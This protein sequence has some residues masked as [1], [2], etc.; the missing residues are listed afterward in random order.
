MTNEPLISQRHESVLSEEEIFDVS[1]TTFHLFDR[2][3]AGAPA[4]TRPLKKGGPCY[5]H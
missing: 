3:N 5:P 1:L 2:E 4:A